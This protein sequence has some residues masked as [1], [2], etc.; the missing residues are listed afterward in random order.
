MLAL[1]TDED[2]PVIILS[3][4]SGAKMFA[5]LYMLTH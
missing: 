2:H 3:T 4:K 5:G 1:K